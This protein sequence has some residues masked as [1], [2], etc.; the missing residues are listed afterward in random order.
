MSLTRISLRSCG[1]LCIPLLVLASLV[2]GPSTQA[3]VPDLVVQVGDTVAASGETNTVIS[4]FLSN[5]ADSIVG[6]NLWLRLDI[7]TIMGFQN[8]SATV[9]DTLWDC[10]Q[11]NQDST[12]CLDSVI[13]DTNAYLS[14]IGSYDLTGTLIENWQYVNVTSLSQVGLDLNIAALADHPLMVGSGP[15]IPP[16]QD[17]LLIKILADVNEIPDTAQNRTV[18]IE[19]SEQD[20]FNFS[21]NDGTSIGL[22]TVMVLDTSYWRCTLWGGSNCLQWLEVSLP[23]YDS[24]S[25]Q[26]LERSVVDPD[27][28]ILLDGS[29]RVN[30]SYVCGNIMA[31]Y[32]QLLTFRISRTWCHTCL[33][34]VR[35]RCRWERQTSI[36][37]LVP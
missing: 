28:A 15:S 8:D 5:Y 32:R 33:R 2:I 31:S 1:I 37:V 30:P 26:L 20:H 13:A 6:F 12:Q 34:A 18:N 7:S 14:Y 10:L 4:V 23:P 22:M 36:A 27:K 29:L 16:Q 25:T 24:T 11:W 9:I 21:R 35:R 3:Q 19:I 17:G